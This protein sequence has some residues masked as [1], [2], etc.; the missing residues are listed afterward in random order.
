MKKVL[1][2]IG[3]LSVKSY[4]LMIT[5][6][7]LTGY[8]LLE[9]RAKK[10]GYNKDN[11]FDMFMLTLIFGVL[12]GKL[13]FI[14]TDIQEIISNPKV[15]LNVGE[16]FVVYGAMIVG[17]ISIYYYCKKKNWDFLNIFDL[18]VPSLAIGQGFGRIGC[19][20]AGCCYGR[21]TNL[22]IGVEF[23]VDSMAPCGIRLHPTQ[24]YSSI[25]DFILAGFLLWY[26]KK[27]RKSG[28][29]CA[30]YLIIYSIGRFLVEFLRNDPR[31]NVSILSTSQFISLFVFIIGIFIYN[32]DKIKKIYNG[33]NG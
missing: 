25:F 9:L 20:L 21:E 18:T 6:G 10:K 23:P 28:K 32:I 4:G 31:G 2:E 17:I 30:L 3:G 19:F 5:I 11:I 29:V 24:I 7:I 15:L 1:F 8:Y 16:G 22:P 14:I 33:K 26:A 27:E 13:M 12:G